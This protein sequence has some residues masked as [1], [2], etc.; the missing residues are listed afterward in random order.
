M[1][2]KQLQDDE[3][4]LGYN[5]WDCPVCLDQIK[6]PKMLRCQHSFCLDPCLQNMVVTEYRNGRK[7]IKCAICDKSYVVNSLDAI[8]DNLQM[9]NLLEIRQKSVNDDSDNA[10]HSNNLTLELV[11]KMRNGE[12]LTLSVTPSFTIFEIKGQIQSIKEINPKDQ[13]LSLNGSDLNDNEKLSRSQIENSVI[14]LSHKSKEISIQLFENSSTKF[15]TIKLDNIEGTEFIRKIKRMI[16]LKKGIPHHVQQLYLGYGNWPEKYK[17]R[18]DESLADNELSKKVFKYGLSLMIYGSIVVYDEGPK[19]FQKIQVE[20]FETIKEF[21]AKA[22]AL[23]YNQGSKFF[24]TKNESTLCIADFNCQ[25]ESLS[26]DDDD[27]TVYE[28][29]IKKFFDPGEF[30][31]TTATSKYSPMQIF[32]RTLTGKTVTFTAFSFTIVEMFKRKIQDKEGIPPD[33]QSIVFAG[34]QLEDGKNFEDY[35]IK[36]RSTLHLSLKVRGN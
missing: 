20:A 10:G 4:N 17:L 29:G 21:K 3:D 26:N 7:K 5:L 8:P 12:T 14:W 28:Y 31:F 6:Q 9:K 34:Q 30:I 23:H 1:A 15:E 22:H 36:E 18:N 16:S 2:A 13:V 25:L 27:K 19:I 24:G 33:Q 35:N 32:V 11:V